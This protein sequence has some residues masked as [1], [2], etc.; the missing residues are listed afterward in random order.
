VRSTERARELGDRRW[1][2]RLDA[3]HRMVREQLVR[4]RGRQID[5]AGDGLFAAFDGPARGIRC[6]AAVVRQ[7]ARLGVQLGAGIHTRECEVVGEKLGGLAVHLGARVCAVAGAGQVWASATV[8][9]LVAGSAIR[10]EDRGLHALK[11]IPEER[12]L[13]AV[14]VDEAA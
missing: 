5:T 7:A 4:F 9:D 3:H 13:F 11:G 8:K 6:A 14:L 12:R 1:S 2:D 10:F